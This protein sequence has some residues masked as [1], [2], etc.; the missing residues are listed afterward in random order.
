MSVSLL[1]RALV[2]RLVFRTDTHM[3]DLVVYVD[4]AILEV[5]ANNRTIVSAVAL[6]GLNSSSRVGVF[7]VGR[8]AAAGVRL[9][10]WSLRAIY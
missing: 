6:S 5:C 9:Q 8:A 3:L 10:A 2:F 4:G 1:G 7:G